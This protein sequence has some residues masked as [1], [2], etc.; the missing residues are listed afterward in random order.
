L[1]LGGATVAIVGAVTMATSL[2]SRDD[3]SLCFT[4]TTAA[5]DI[6]LGGKGYGGLKH[7]STVCFVLFC[8]RQRFL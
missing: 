1:P 5:A 4:T 6:G 2:P 3:G 8:R 7:R